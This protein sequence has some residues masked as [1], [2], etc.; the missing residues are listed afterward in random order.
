[1]DMKSHKTHKSH[2]ENKPHEKPEPPHNM[3]VVG[4]KSVYLSHLPMFMTPHNFQAIFEAEFSKGGKSAQEIY[5]KDRQS[6]P[7]VK[8]YTVMPHGS[9]KLPTLFRPLPPPRSSF[10]ATLFRGHLER[11]NEELGNF[12]VKIKR[13]IYAEELDGTRTKPDELTYILFGR[14]EELFLAHLIAAPPPDFDQIISVKIDGHQFTE[15]ELQTGV[16]VVFLDR[17][18]TVVERLKEKEKLEGRGHVTGAHQFLDL[19]VEGV[20]EFYFEESE[21]DAEGTMGTTEE[22]QKAGF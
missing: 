8:M 19:N 18:N 20:R 4:E 22:E 3:M 14:P 15:Q 1:M 5:F 12:D 9:F 11:D 13:V 17:A 6:H 7:K 21:L 16:R 2:G 10:Q